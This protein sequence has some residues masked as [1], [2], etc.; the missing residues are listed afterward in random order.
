[1]SLFALGV[2]VLGV[3]FYHLRSVE[4]RLEREVRLAAQEVERLRAQVILFTESAV[5]AGL[6]FGDLLEARGIGRTSVAAIVQAARPVYDLAR[7]RAGN[8]FAIGRSLDGALRAIRYQVDADRLLWVLHRGDGEL[9]AE[10]RTVPSTVEVVGVAGVVQQSLFDAVTGAGERPELA[11]ELAN[12]FGWDLDF[13]TDTRRGDSFRLLVEKKIYQ[14]GQS[15]AYGRVLAA[16]YTNEGHAYRAVLFRDPSGRPAYYA[17]D[18][19][20][21]QK[22]FLRSPLKFSAPISSRF[23]R[24][25][26]HPILR[27]HR[28]HLGIDYAAP[29]GTPVQ[30]IGEGRV[31][32]AGTQGGGGKSVH[33]RHANGYETFYLHL[34]RIL[35]STGQRVGQGDRIGLVGSSGLA[36][37]P[38]L[39]FRIRQHGQYRNFTALRLPPARPVAKADWD[40]FITTRERWLGQL[41]AGSHEAAQSAPQEVRR[42]GSQVIGQ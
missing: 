7:V 5:P 2:V 25:R 31:V 22:V 9:R 34:S 16:E 36:T 40:E 12:I 18:G 1:M 26:F 6:A 30:T 38:H 32:F 27:R 41:P 35:V 15:A 28:P 10:L 24:S 23:S 3:S 21:L 14:N 42:S 29:A 39:D 19:K 20:S 37:G 33:I 13:Y 4:L 17:P 11:L 8:H